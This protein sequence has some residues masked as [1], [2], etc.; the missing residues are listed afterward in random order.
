MIISLL[1]SVLN[2]SETTITIQPTVEP[3]AIAEVV[4]DNELVNGPFHEGSKT[5]DLGDLSVVVTF[6]WEADPLGA[7]AITVT[8]PDGIICKPASCTLIVNEGDVG[9]LYLYEWVGL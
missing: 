2:L 5:I 9:T 8:P 6:D 1:A 7:D 3:G 4:F